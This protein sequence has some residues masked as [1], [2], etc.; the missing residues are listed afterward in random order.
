MDKLTACQSIIY[1]MI[2]GALSKVDGKTE[3]KI[4]KAG[5][6]YKNVELECWLKDLKTL[7]KEDQLI[8]QT[9]G[10]VVE[11]GTS[12]LFFFFFF[13]LLIK[14]CLHNIQLL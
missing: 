11:N 6:K 7:E 10:S 14:L 13:F 2:D 3:H 9:L 5:H 8:A 4:T 12:F 1:D